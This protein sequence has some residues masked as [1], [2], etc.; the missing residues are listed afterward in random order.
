[1][2]IAFDAKYRKFS[3]KDILVKR[4]TIFI[5]TRTMAMKVKKKLINT[6]QQPIAKGTVSLCLDLYTDDFR[7]K[8]IRMYM[9]RIDAVF[10]MSHVTLTVRYFATQAQTGDNISVTVRDIL[11]EYGIR[12]DDIPVTT[13]H[14]SNVVATLR[15]NIRLDNMCRRL[16]T[17]LESAW[18][19]NMKNLRQW[20]TK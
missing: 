20:N 17:L 14:G 18:K 13:D 15:N 6:L 7:K 2:C 16:H 9:Q 8:F 10:N 4:K 12:E 5:L 1:M 19:L 11:C 3:I